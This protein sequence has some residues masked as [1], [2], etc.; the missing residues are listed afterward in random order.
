MTSVGN[1]GLIGSVVAGCPRLVLKLSRSSEP[2]FD[3]VAN[4][5]DGNLGSFVA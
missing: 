1:E 3:W 2:P 5:S 4:S